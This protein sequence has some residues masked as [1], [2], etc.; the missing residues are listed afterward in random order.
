M[1]EAILD[2]PTADGVMGVVAKRPDGAGPFPVVVLFHDGPGVRDATHEL[3][4][5]IAAAGYYVVAPDRYYRYG[6]FVHVAPE[7]LIAAEPDS[8]LMRDFFAMVMATTDDLIR[9]DVDVLL[10]YLASDPAARPGRM[11]CIGYCNGARSVLRTVFD[12][13]GRFAAGVGLH[14]SFCVSPDDDSPHA[15]VSSLD[16]WFYFAFGEADHTASVEHNQPLI[17]ALRTLGDRATVEILPGADHGFAVPGPK[18][19]EAAATLAHDRAIE[20]F[21]RELDPRIRPGVE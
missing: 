21:N 15:C 10:D 1:H 4:R 20:L 3:V 14:P 19:H 17:D 7:E 12:H 16:G 8:K 11:G 6:R 9:A 2:L 5:R 13:P 18:Y